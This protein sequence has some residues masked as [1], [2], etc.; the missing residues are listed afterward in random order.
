MR[1]GRI[2]LAE[3][4]GALVVHTLRLGESGVI[5]KGHRLTAA[6]LDRLSRDGN[7]VPVGAHF[8]HRRDDAE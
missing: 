5:K 8:Y 7:I 3:A 6:D 1:L 2:A 4:E